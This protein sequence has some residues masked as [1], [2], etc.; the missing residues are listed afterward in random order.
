[1]FVFEHYLYDTEHFIKLQ[2]QS[3]YK[4]IINKRLMWKHLTDE[5]Q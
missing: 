4:I 3:F 1:M 5:K 2:K